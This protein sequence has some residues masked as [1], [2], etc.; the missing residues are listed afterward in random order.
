MIERQGILEQVQSDIQQ[1]TSELEN[2]ESIYGRQLKEYQ[3]HS[4]LGPE[5]QTQK[6]KLSVFNCNRV[7]QAPTN[8]TIF[9][10][11]VNNAGTVFSQARQLFKLHSGI[12]FREHK[13]SVLRVVS[14]CRTAS[15]A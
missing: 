5:I 11:S 12:R 6:R 13:C 3:S 15:Q 8:G 9:Q 14:T 10:L 1:A 7:L 4:G 2:M